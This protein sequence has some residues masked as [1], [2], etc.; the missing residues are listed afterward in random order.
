MAGHG[1]ATSP[2]VSGF[3]VMANRGVEFPLVDDLIWTG[4]VEQLNI[5]G[6]LQDSPDSGG[7]QCKKRLIRQNESKMR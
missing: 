2:E 7:I 3:F 6:D 5:T 4:S 1:F